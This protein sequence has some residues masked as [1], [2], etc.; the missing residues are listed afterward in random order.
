MFQLFIEKLPTTSKSAAVDVGPVQ[1]MLVSRL[2]KHRRKRIANGHTAAGFQT[3][4]V[5]SGSKNRWLAPMEQW[6]VYKITGKDEI[7]AKEEQRLFSQMNAL[8]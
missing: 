3:C 4:M 5:G 2:A 1:V 6:S 8:K 7:H